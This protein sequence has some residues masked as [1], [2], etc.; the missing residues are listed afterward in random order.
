ML[1]LQQASLLLCNAGAAAISAGTALKKHTSLRHA[2]RYVFG[3][4]ASA[5]RQG[6]A[7]FDVCSHVLAV[8]S[9]VVAHGICLVFDLPLV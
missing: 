1:Q 9:C 5:M 6:R 4:F 3:H 2:S 7:G 8:G